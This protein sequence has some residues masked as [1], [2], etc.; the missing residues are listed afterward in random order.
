[1]KNIDTQWNKNYIVYQQSI[2]FELCLLSRGIK[3]QFF[4]FNY[5]PGSIKKPFV[6]IGISSRQ[7]PDRRHFSVHDTSR[8]R[9]IS[10]NNFRFSWKLIYS[11]KNSSNKST[12]SKIAA[13]LESSLKIRRTF[14]S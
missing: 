2:N 8:W 4:S 1:M 7:L 9:R 14:Y 11:D 5:D 13:R 12:N 3:L 10:F 6:S